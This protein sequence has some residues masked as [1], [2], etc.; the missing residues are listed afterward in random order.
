MHWI[1]CTDR[2]VA[3]TG[4]IPE[5]N[6]FGRLPIPVQCQVLAFVWFMS[7]SEVTRSVSDRFDVTLTAFL[8]NSGDNFIAVGLGLVKNCNWNTENQSGR[9]HRENGTTF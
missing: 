7:N 1:L 8:R 6:C 9:S 4:I 5:G 3:A 2:E